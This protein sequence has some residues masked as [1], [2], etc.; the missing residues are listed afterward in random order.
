MAEK[1]YDKPAGKRPTASKPSVRLVRPGEA[2]FSPEQ[3]TI[4]MQHARDIV[5]AALKKAMVEVTNISPTEKQQL[6]KK[7]FF[8]KVG[9]FNAEG[10][11]LAPASSFLKYICTKSDTDIAVMAEQSIQ[12]TI[13]ESL[14]RTEIRKTGKLREKVSETKKEGED[15]PSES[16]YQGRVDTAIWAYLQTLPEPLDI[17]LFDEL[18]RI[19]KSTERYQTQRHMSPETLLKNVGSLVG[20]LKAHPERISHQEA[21]PDDDIPQ[22]KKSLPIEDVTGKFRKE[23]KRSLWG[24]I[25]DT[26]EKT[27][28]GN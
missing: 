20:F 21:S 11:I 19:M 2:A 3:L 26:L 28:F 24:K 25:T 6:Y 15:S 12:E 14:D 16:E 8:S 7:I 10:Q 9:G 5:L 18:V 13:K 4:K 27:M 23:K 22:Q 17:A 1:S